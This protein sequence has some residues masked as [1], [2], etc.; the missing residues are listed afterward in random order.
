MTDGG[1][2]GK[3]AHYASQTISAIL[4]EPCDAADLKALEIAA[5]FRVGAL[6]RRRSLVITSGAEPCPTTADVTP[7]P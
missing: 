2:I 7:P 5:P 4:A 6:R 1:G 3:A